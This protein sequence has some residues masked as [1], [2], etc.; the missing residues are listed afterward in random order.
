MIGKAVMQNMEIEDE[1][2]QTH[3]ISSKAT[4]P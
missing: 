1:D 2:K 3:F 4:G